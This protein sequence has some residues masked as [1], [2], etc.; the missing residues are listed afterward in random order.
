MFVPFSPLSCGVAHPLAAHAHISHPKDIFWHRSMTGSQT[1]FATA[2]MRTARVPVSFEKV[3]CPHTTQCRSNPVSGSRL[4][5]TGNISNVGPRLS[6]IS[7]PICSNL[8]YTDG[9]P[10]HKKPQLAGT[11][12]IPG[13]TISS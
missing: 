5:K 13:P 3:D 10:I 7:L 11:Y 4:R 2:N 6:A 12:R 9:Q 8:E 1:G